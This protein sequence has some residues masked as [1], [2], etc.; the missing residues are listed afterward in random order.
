M[1]SS[2][3]T[4]QTRIR[5]LRKFFLNSNTRAHLRGLEAEFGE[6]TNG[7]RVELNRMESADLLNSVRDGKKKLYFANRKHPLFNEIHNIIVKDTGIDRIVEKVAHR[8]GNLEAVYLV[9]D[10]AKGNDTN[11]IELVITGNDIDCD[12]LKRKTAQ[13]VS[14]TGREVT[15]SIVDPESIGELVERYGPGGI[16]LLWKDNQRILNYLG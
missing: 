7:L 1:I 6:S 12:Y 14:L 11:S 8:L 10:M 9:G 13:A 3:I 5:L 16:L 2:L 15:C 4:S